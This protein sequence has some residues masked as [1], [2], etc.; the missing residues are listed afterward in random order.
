MKNY[1]PLLIVAALAI[2]G[3]QA[4]KKENVTA[5]ARVPVL[6]SAIQNYSELPASGTF[7]PFGFASISNE[8]ATLGRVL[9]FET[10]L[11]VNN[12]TSCGTC[13]NQRKGFGTHN[14]VDEGFNGAMTSRNVPGIVNP[15]L[16]SSYFWDMRESN[17]NAMVTQPIANHV[18]MG[19]EE[20]EYMTA[21]VTALP[22]YNQL[23]QSAYGDENVT[24]ERIGDALAHFV[25]SM[26]SCNSKFDQGKN[27][28]FTNFTEEENIGR[29]L[30]M[31][32]LPCAGCH[33]GDNFAGWG[34]QA[35]NIGLEENYADP[36]VPG[37]D[38]NTGQPMNGW[39]K[40]PSLRNVALTAPYMHDGRFT[41]LEDVVNF[42]NSGIKAHNQ[43]SFNLRVGWN[44]GGGIFP[45]DDPNNTNPNGV[46]PLRM[47]LST[48]EKKA[49]VAFLNTL[50]DESI[51]TQNKFSDPF[52]IQP[53]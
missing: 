37:T 27:S 19:L 15:G 44:G 25:R 17:L 7:N 26:V 29:Q 36:G 28:G 41:S 2:A 31:N 35:L 43:L 30:F 50:T 34:S 14:S 45:E 24:S 13:H 6:P 1:L 23:F 21:K 42:Y 22:Y 18:E 9:F 32:D 12:R 5:G 20:P 52:V 10:Q 39:F 48:V 40:V 47:N 51:I 8:K 33:G 49:L 53:Q 38:W 11:S 4:C 3:M 16:Q 46:Q